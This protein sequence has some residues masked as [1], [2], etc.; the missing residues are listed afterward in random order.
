MLEASPVLLVVVHHNMQIKHPRPSVVDVA[1][2]RHQLARL[3]RPCRYPERQ[4]DEEIRF[5]FYPILCFPK[6]EDDM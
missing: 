4:D 6:Q 5:L 1:H 2:E 3:F